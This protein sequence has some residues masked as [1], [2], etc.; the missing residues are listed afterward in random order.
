MRA[1]ALFL[2]A[3]LAH[4]AQAQLDTTTIELDVLRAPASPASVLL[5]VA[6]SDIQRPSDLTSFMV[7]LRQ[8]TSDLSQL[9]KNYAIDL[10]PAWLLGA[11]NS[12]IDM[13]G[14]D[15]DGTE[16][17]VN[18]GTTIWQSLVIS[19]AVKDP[20]A[21]EGTTADPSAGFGFKFSLVRGGV[22]AASRN[23]LIKVR[24]ALRNYNYALHDTVRVV[25]ADDPMLKEIS[26][27][28]DSVKLT[29]NRTD[30]ALDRADLTENDRIH[31]ETLRTTLAALKVSYARQKADRAAALS[32]PVSA[33]ASLFAEELS[34]MKMAAEKFKVERKGFFWDLAGGLVLDFR[35]RRLDN[36]TITSAGVWTTLSWETDEH[37]SFQLLGRYL[38]NPGSVFMGEADSLETQDIRTMDGGT[39]L[40]FDP[41]EGRFTFSG[42]A[43]YRTVLDMDGIE[44][45]WRVVANT[46]YATGSNDLLT[47]SFGRNFDGTLTKDGNL[48]AALSFLV[49][50]GGK[51]KL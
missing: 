2:L 32:V 31:L 15:A 16:K 17:P 1:R 26:A 50:L 19:S 35:D 29:I 47:F 36:S 3:F 4:A 20:D 37:V 28:M 34:A 25:I 8:A 27:A 12:A 48:I 7:S 11:H 14:I 21:V 33:D 44:P 46:Q 9:P 49:G 39:R 40:T 24:T 13:L 51:R 38:L 42:E 10:A 22:T 45:T 41:P 6:E 18:V 30:S 23:S 5:G 43:L